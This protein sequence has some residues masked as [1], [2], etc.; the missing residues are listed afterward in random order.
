MPMLDAYIPEGALS[1]QAERELLS[2]LTDILL[3]HEGA[4]PANPVA[5]AIAWVFLHRPAAD[6][7]GRHPKRWKCWWSKR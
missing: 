2:D 6:R 7:T 5:R 1:E 4:D 3:E